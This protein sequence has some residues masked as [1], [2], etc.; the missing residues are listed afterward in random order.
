M[1]I[2]TNGI[3]VDNRGRILLILRDDTRTWAIPGGALDAGELPTDGVVRE[4][5]E[6]TGFH[7]FPSR[8]VGLYHW[9]DRSDDFLILVFRCIIDGGEMTRSEESLQVKFAPADSLPRSLL[10]LHRERLGRGL[11]H[12][13]STP[14]WG[15]QGSPRS[16]IIW[17][18]FVGPVIYAVKDMRR[19]YRGEPLYQPPPSWSV[20]SFVVIQN[21]AGDVLWV[22]RTDFD[23]W[24]LPGG[25]S[26]PGE[27]PWSTAVRETR[28]ETGLDVR[29]LECSGVYVKPKLNQM[30]FSFTA[31]VVGG[32]LTTGAE[33]AEF[34]Y[35]PPGDEPV[36]TLQ[37][38]V[39]R[40]ADAVSFQG[41][42]YFRIQD[43]PSGLELH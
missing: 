28:E 11:A 19:R 27:A 23:L 33:A 13:G 32:E 8:L 26:E 40:A 39:E 2:G 34:A 43:Q 25:G 35:F 42:P 31:H 38:H 30:L 5:Q 18:R 21:E 14:Y 1:F 4:V 10:G 24:N 6:E 37:K 41:V 36:N 29:L 12:D 3:V 9:N 15:E 7:V 22:K 17:N 16:M 20:A